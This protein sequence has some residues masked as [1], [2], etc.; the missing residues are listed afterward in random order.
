MWPGCRSQ[1]RPLLAA[2]T[3]SRKKRGA[4]FVV[5]I[6][7]SFSVHAIHFQCRRVLATATV[8]KLSRTS[9]ASTEPSLEHCRLRR[10]L[11]QNL[12]NPTKPDRISSDSYLYGIQYLLSFPPSALQKCQSLICCARHCRSVFCARRKLGCFNRLQG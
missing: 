10:K 5:A 11:L 6:S 1:L 2:E 7:S 12:W 4:L 8:S 3:G 9:G